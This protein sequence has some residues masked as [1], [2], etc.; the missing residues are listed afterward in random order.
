MLRLKL[1]L[2]RIGARQQHLGTHLGLSK[3]KTAQ[4]INHDLW[5]Q[6]RDSAALREMVGAWLKERGALPE[7][8]GTWWQPLPEDEA[9]HLIGPGRGRGKR[10]GVRDHS[11]VT[12]D[13]PP[14]DTVMLL[15]GQKLTDVARKH[16]A[17]FRD[18]FRGEIREHAD[19]YI[20][21]DARY[22]REAM[23]QTALHGGM[24]AIVGESGSGKSTLREDL[25]DRIQAEGEPILLIQPYVIDMEERSAKRRTLGARDIAAAIVHTLAPHQGVRQDGQARFLQVHRL[26]ADSYRSGNKHCLVIEEAHDLP[27]ATLRHLKRYL[28]LKEGFHPL[29]SV[30][31]LGQPELGFRL[32][33]LDASIREIVQRCEVLTLRPLDGALEGFIGHK[34]GRQGRRVEEIL[35][36][37]G[38]DAIRARLTIDTGRGRG[39]TGPVSLLYPLAVQNL[40]TAA[41][42]QAAELGLPV[43]SADVIREV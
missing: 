5:P 6:H 36:P 42:N 41:L 4:W 31:L 8:L 26:L 9:R 27:T 14:E 33:E 12:S 37:D 34:L 40:L 11:A 19:L 39:S 16:F 24:T 43:V 23:W 13:T 25:A 21:P 2:A 18:P 3:A 28:E 10:A 7:E 30:V 29:L 38:L 20:T 35:T 32:S 1:I 22:C 17:L 15:R